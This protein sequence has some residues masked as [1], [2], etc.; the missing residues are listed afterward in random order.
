MVQEGHLG[1]T[2]CQVSDFGSWHD[3]TVCEFEFH[4]GLSALRMEPTLFYLFLFF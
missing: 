2:V 1:G 4:M 3:F